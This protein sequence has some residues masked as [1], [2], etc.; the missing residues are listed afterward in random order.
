MAAPK[1]QLPSFEKSIEELESIVERIEAG[2]IDLD[3]SL[4]IFERGTKLVAHCRKVLDQAQKKIAELAIDEQGRV[5]TG[6][7]GG[8]DEPEGPESE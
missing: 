4:A 6:I 8:G 2:D 5:T 1:E 7:A 3:Q